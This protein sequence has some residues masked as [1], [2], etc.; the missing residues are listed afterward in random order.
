MS[1]PRRIGP[2]PNVIV[3]FLLVLALFGGMYG[4][5]SEALATVFTWAFQTLWALTCAW[6]CVWPFWAARKTRL[7]VVPIWIAVL[8]I[9]TAVL[10]QPALCLLTHSFPPV[11]PKP[12]LAFALV[13]TFTLVGPLFPLFVGIVLGS[14]QARRSP[15]KNPPPPPVSDPP[16][17]AA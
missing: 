7:F 14:I 9:V 6:R 12:S 4:F 3:V 5:R 13:M 8:A 16:A 1:T 11:V 15:A 17:P 2:T 10:H